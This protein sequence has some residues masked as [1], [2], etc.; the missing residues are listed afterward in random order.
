MQTKIRLKCQEL[1]FIL[2]H[3]PV[4]IAVHLLT[5]FKGTDVFIS[6]KAGA[7]KTVSGKFIGPN[8]KLLF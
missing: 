1:R 5:C 7:N 2:Q 6:L 8:K 4:W 3:F